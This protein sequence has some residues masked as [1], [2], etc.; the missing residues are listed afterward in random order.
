LVRLY[1]VGQENKGSQAVM[2]PP[3]FLERVSTT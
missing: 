1:Q 2:G 3:G